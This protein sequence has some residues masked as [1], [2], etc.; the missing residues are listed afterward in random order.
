M[1]LNLSKVTE[2]LGLLLRMQL[3]PCSESHKGKAK[4]TRGPLPCLSEGPGITLDVPTG[5][6]A[7]IVK[8]TAVGS[9][10][11]KYHAGVPVVAQ[12]KRI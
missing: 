3:S 11:Q 9:V 6:A 4:R 12:Q 5:Q 10:T 1:A 7:S 8:Q 2:S